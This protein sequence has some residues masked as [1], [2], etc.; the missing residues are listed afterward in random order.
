AK[1]DHG[2]TLLDETIRIPLIITGPDVP[3]GQSVETQVSLAD[4][5]PTIADWAGIDPP[6]GT[7]GRSLLPLLQGAELEESL[8]YAEVWFHDRLALGR[9]LKRCLAAGELLA[10]GYETFPCERA[11]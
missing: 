8:A 5:A 4:V 2:E 11:V 9:Y 7:E 10:E 6:E 3:L 1:F